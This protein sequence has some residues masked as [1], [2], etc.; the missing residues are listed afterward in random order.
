MST[1]IQPSPPPLLAL[2]RNLAAAAAESPALAQGKVRLRSVEPVA[3][4]VALEVEARGVHFL[5]N[6]PYRVAL[7]VLRTSRESTLCDVRIAEGRMVGK[8]FNWG[9]KL[10]PNA[11]LNELLRGRAGGAL[12]ME[13]DRILVNHQA[14]IAW[15][16]KK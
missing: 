15:L 5:V 9:L 4:G 14:L 6:G 3:D 13:G 11:L 12:H 2:L 16:L 10:I 7:A 1:E 8:L